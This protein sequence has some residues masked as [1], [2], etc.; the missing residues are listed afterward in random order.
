MWSL[1]NYSLVK[2]LDK[3]VCHMCELSLTSVFQRT[4]NCRVILLFYSDLMILQY[5]VHKNSFQ[6]AS[7]NPGSKVKVTWDMPSEDIWPWSHR[8]PGIASLVTNMEKGFSATSKISLFVATQGKKIYGMLF[9]ASDFDYG[10]EGEI[11]KVE[12]HVC[13]SMKVNQS[14]VF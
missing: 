13:S 12:E 7:T 9:D 14:A 1:V 3:S 4:N 2:Q 8:K 6:F 10:F 11:G 5:F